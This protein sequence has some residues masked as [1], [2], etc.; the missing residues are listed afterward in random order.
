MAS[1]KKSV[2]ISRLKKE[3]NTAKTEDNSTKKANRATRVIEEYIHC[4]TFEKKFIT[5]HGL[6][7]LAQRLIQWANKKESFILTEFCLEEGIDSEQLKRWS[8]ECSELKRALSYAIS[9]LAIIREKEGSKTN[10]MYKESMVIRSLHRY[11]KEW[12]EDNKY[13]VQLKAMQASIQN[14]IEGKNAEDKYI[15]IKDMPVEAIES[16]DDD[17]T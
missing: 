9:K 2:A 11:S 7:E 15:M 14:Q 10:G 5:D 16:K 12:D 6:I 4:S 8:L 13:H 1:T 17:N 3:S